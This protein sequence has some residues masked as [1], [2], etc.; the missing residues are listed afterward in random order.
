MILSAF[1]PEGIILGPVVCAQRPADA[2]ERSIVKKKK[3][4][5]VLKAR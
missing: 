2:A 3:T 5:F 1:L 4:D